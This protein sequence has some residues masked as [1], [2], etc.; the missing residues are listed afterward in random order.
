MKDPHLLLKATQGVKGFIAW[1]NYKTAAATAAKK[2]KKNTTTTSSTSSSSSSSSSSAVDPRFKQQYV[3]GFDGLSL[4][5]GRLVSWVVIACGLN[6]VTDRR[7]LFEP[8]VKGGYHMDIMNLVGMGQVQVR[9]GE[10]G[11]LGVRV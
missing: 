2:K 5:V 9:G 11:V 3:S 4:S 6:D 1:A 8:L 7:E 10:V